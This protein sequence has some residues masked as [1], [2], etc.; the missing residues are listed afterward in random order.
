MVVLDHFIVTGSLVFSA[1]VLLSWGWRFEPRLSQEGHQMQNNCQMFCASLSPEE[2]NSQKNRQQ[3]KGAIHCLGR[4]CEL[5]I[6]YI[7][8]F[9]TVHLFTP[10]PLKCLWSGVTGGHIYSY[11]GWWLTQSDCLLCTECL[12]QKK[13]EEVHVVCSR[14]DFVLLNLKVKASKVLCNLENTSLFKI[15]EL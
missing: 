2:R 13:E 5:T 14:L 1:A 9:F 11:L 12:W 10:S 7:F 4:S 15:L 3:H 8:V 6:H